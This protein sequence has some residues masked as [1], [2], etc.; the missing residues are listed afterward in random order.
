MKKKLLI[1]N[2]SQLVTC[3]GGPKFG[4][5]IKELGIIIN[6]AVVIDTHGIITHV[7]NSVKIIETLFGGKYSNLP[8]DS[9]FVCKEIT[10]EYEII[11]AKEKCVMPG[12]IDSHTHF[13]FG[14]YRENE[15][16]RRM[17]GESYISI[18]KA[19]GGIINSVRDTRK[20]SKEDLFNIGKERLQ[21][22]LEQGITTI[23]GKS[24]YGLNT[25]TEL[26]QLR[27]MEKL[28][29]TQAVDVVPTFM[30]AHAIPQEY[31]SNP[32]DYVNLVIEE[33]LPAVTQEN[34]AQF[35]DVFCEQGV[36]S[37]EQSK[38]ILL[39]GQKL[40]L[41]SKIHAEELIQLGGAELA[42]EIKAVSAD[43]LLFASDNGIKMMAEAGV[44][45][46][47]LPTTAFSLRESYAKAR[48]MIDNG[49]CVALGSDFNPGSC[50]TFSV[51]LLFAL[52]ALQMHMSV[53]EIINAL[54]INAAKA[55]GREK[56]IGSIEIG[57]QADLIILNAPSYDFLSYRIAT[58]MVKKVIKKGQIVY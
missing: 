29:K 8:V 52:A 24:G 42:A 13:I 11:D 27:V 38:K 53:P 43:H 41:K 14:G 18:M 48:F 10:N 44:V 1:I 40:G 31:K 47:L 21:L 28:N 23:E 26:K 35:C 7:G 25:E 19:G 12:F 58:N 3:S 5:K 51:P 57:K 22:M 30:G 33:M 39:S 17:A 34:L 4:E 2:S 54:T 20:A 16:A 49:A 15:F 36:F 45:C 32:D 46:T 50:C 56:S 6:G 9:L 37:V 55:I